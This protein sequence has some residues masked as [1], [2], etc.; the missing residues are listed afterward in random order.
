M[1]TYSRKGN[2]LSDGVS[3]LLIAQR[4]RVTPSKSK[5]FLLK[6]IGKNRVYISSLY[7]KEPN[8]E[9]EYKGNRYTLT[10]DHTSATIKAKVLTNV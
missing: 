4:K 10:L 6:I 5:Y 3:T 7:G 1:N 8:Y 9:F 2:T